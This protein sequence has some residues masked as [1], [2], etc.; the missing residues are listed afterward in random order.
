MRKTKPRQYL[1]TGQEI[2]VMRRLFKGEVAIMSKHGW[3][4]GVYS[5]GYPCTRQINYLAKLGY[6]EIG[7]DTMGQGV[8][9]ITEKGKKIYGQAE[10]IEAATKGSKAV[11]KAVRSAEARLSQG[12]KQARGSGFGARGPEDG[13]RRVS[14]PEKTQK[15]KRAKTPQGVPA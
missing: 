13:A 15:R 2:L 1:F 10:R 3:S 8:A 11:S 9:Y 6:A 7:T 4:F 5:Y 14:V 12:T